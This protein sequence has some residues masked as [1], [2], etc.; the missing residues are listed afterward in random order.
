[1]T[2]FPINIVVSDNL[3]WGPGQPI[4][5]SEFHWTNSSVLLFQD[6]SQGNSVYQINMIH[7]IKQKY[8]DLQV[9]GGNGES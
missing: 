8:A 9:I 5:A 2:P 3:I 4:I 6:S 7:Y 1:M